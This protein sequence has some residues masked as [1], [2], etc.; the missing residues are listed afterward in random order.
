VKKYIHKLVEG[1]DEEFV[2]LESVLWAIEKCEG[3]ISY[4]KYLLGAPNE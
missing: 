1:T 4:L 3:S 2:K